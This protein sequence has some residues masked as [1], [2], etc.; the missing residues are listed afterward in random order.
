MDCSTLSYNELRKELKKRNAKSSGKKAVLLKRLQDL[1]ANET[2]TSSSK[3]RSRSEDKTNTNTTTKKK[4]SPSPSKK[5]TKTVDKKRLR[6]EDKT[7]KTTTTTTS[8]KRTKT[9]EKKKSIPK[10]G[11][12]NDETLTSKRTK[13]FENSNNNTKINPNKPTFNQ[14]RQA[15]LTKKAEKYWKNVSSVKY[16]PELVREIYF[17]DLERGACTPSQI[18]L[19]EFSQYLESYLCP[20][21]SSK[22]ATLSSM[23]SIVY[24]INRKASERVPIFE[25][26]RNYQ[27]TFRDFFNSIVNL[28]TNGQDSENTKLTQIERTALMKFLV[29]CFNSFE[30]EIVRSCVAPLVHLP[31]WK[32]VSKSRR[33][34]EFADT[35]ELE[36]H[37]KDQ[38]ISGMNL[39]L[40]DVS[41]LYSIFEEFLNT[42]QSGTQDL[43]TLRYCERVAELTIDLL[44]QLRTRRFLRVLLDDMHFCV[45]ASMS[46]F[47]KKNGLLCELVK[48]AEYYLDFEIDDITGE[49]LS[50]TRMEARHYDRISRLQRDLFNHIENGNLE[51]SLKTL[52][53]THVSGISNRQHVSEMIRDSNCDINRLS[54][55]MG[56]PV[57]S[58]LE[59]TLEAVSRKFE[60]RQSQIRKINEYSLYPD[61][62]LLWDENVVPEGR[63][64]N[65]DV[66]A[67]PKLNL[68]FL[69]VHDYLLRSFN[70]YRLEACYEIREDVRRCVKDLKPVHDTRKHRTI[71]SGWSRM[72]VPIESFELTEVS[73]ARLGETR[74]ERVRGEI[75]FSLSSYRGEIREEWAALKQHDVVFLL[76][77]RARPSEKESVI[78]IRGAE[79]TQVLD[80]DGV[81]I[82]ELGG[83]PDLRPGGA[84]GSKRTLKVLLDSSQYQRD[85]RFILWPIYLLLHI[86]TT[87]TLIHRYEITPLE[88][89]TCTKRL[90]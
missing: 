77:I 73:R 22:N 20:H 82:N 9:M 32:H 80:E 37:W 30:N 36:K 25:C 87:H 16:S 8:K 54:Q 62:T 48:R 49:A 52:V 76:T 42:V 72:A 27:D 90:T 33:D 14:I 69:T 86:D 5:R 60:K 88:R 3:K 67:L 18:A 81:V 75:R 1:I 29:V 58:S 6:S 55:V 79:V 61:E 7:N 65:D 35:P 68:Q 24:M 66:L 56:I 84:V 44:S 39:N 10:R 21:F 71:L 63:Y 85:V 51:K 47:V 34:V 40:P 31:M 17:E 83:K 4:S 43:P 12:V 57:S 19:L 23:M 15:P 64:E 78:T 89:K 26:F 38:D 41:F 11:R 50:E 59:L 28:I 13:T 45:R 53:M 2:S 74:P 70:L 46:E